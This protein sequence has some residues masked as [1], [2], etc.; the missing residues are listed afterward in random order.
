MKLQNYFLQ[1][2]DSIFLGADLSF[3]YAG[4]KYCVTISNTDEEDLVL[5][6]RNVCYGTLEKIVRRLFPNTVVHKSFCWLQHR[7]LWGE[8]KLLSL[9]CEYGGSKLRVK[10]SKWLSSR[11]GGRL[12]RTFVQTH[13]FKICDCWLQ[14]P[15]F[16]KKLLSLNFEDGGSKLCVTAAKCLLW[17]SRWSLELTFF[18][19]IWFK[20]RFCFL[21]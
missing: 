4:G 18:F 8:K 1:A 9:N 21:Q 7:S 5:R 17:L 3:S 10:A 13:Y 14:L 12:E 20:N 6:L 19:S 2:H 16:G 15:V 11:S